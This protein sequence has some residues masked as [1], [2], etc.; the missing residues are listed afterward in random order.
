MKIFQ[1][2]SLG[3]SVV[4]RNLKLVLWLALF[5]VVT[6][7]IGISML[8]QDM[9]TIGTTTN[10]LALIPWWFWLWALVIF[11]VGIFM[12]SGVL[13]YLNNAIK[14]GSSTW[15]EFIEGA[16]KFFGRIILF[17]LLFLTVLFVAMVVISIITGILS[18][19][20]GGANQQASVTIGV[21]FFILLGMGVFVG[22][23]F[24]VFSPMAIVVGD[25]KLFVG[26][27]KS[28]LFVKNHFWQTI[29]LYLLIIL[30]LILLLQML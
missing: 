8:P 24:F 3:I 11:I 29:G 27:G 17:G 18:V 10:P 15:N 23:I 9:S 12:Q 22:T 2:I 5:Q 19:V 21:I 28:L 6:A 1:A 25:E 14:S 4:S 13:V 30:M 26:I 16:K 20:L 7:L